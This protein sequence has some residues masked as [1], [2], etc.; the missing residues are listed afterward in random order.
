M[1]K[2][3]SDQSRILLFTPPD[4]DLSVDQVDHKVGK[5][6][7]KQLLGNMVGDNYL[8]DMQLYLVHQLIHRTLPPE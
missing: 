7:G 8:T 1:D 4:Q 5:Y 2:V 3:L 6:V